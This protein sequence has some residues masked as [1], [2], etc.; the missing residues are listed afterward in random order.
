MV[1]AP[2]FTAREKGNIQ[3][4]YKE[5]STNTKEGRFTS[6]NIEYML[7]HSASELRHICFRKASSKRHV[8]EARWCAEKSSALLI[9]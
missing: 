4:N 5:A 1:T 3:Q 2:A 6:T 9:E 7:R 8:S